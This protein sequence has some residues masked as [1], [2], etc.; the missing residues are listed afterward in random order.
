MNVYDGLGRAMGI[1]APRH[2]NED[3][4]IEMINNANKYE[5][6]ETS[7][8]DIDVS[9]MSE[10]DKFELIKDIFD[11]QEDSESAMSL[12]KKVKKLCDELEEEYE[13][14]DEE[15]EEEED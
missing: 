14:G 15:E 6:E 1:N 12:C 9:S 4:L 3:E 11:S 8:E 7:P 10:D 13:D 5:E 2:Y